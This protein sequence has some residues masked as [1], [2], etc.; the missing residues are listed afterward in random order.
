M[1][2][3]K[4]MENVIQNLNN[5]VE[6]LKNINETQSKLDNTI[7]ELIKIQETIQN[8][9]DII[10]DY[11]KNINELENRHND[12]KS[13]FDT[14]LQDYKKLHSAFELLDIELKKLNTRQENV[15]KSLID[16]NELIKAIK[17]TVSQITIA[18]ENILKS[19]Q[20][21]FDSL[22]KLTSDN[23]AK[24]LEKQKE[25]TQN[26]ENSKV[27]IKR[28]IANLCDNIDNGIVKQEEH[29]S[30]IVSDM[31]DV[32]KESGRLQKE[33]IEYMNFFEKKN[34]IRFSVLTGIGIVGLIILII[35]LFV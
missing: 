27:E 26:L 21:S 22:K 9:K 16:I 3:Y 19:Q 33:L 31:K 13:Q 17:Q 23:F 28:D 12:I 15:E 29:Y 5:Y 4:E 7:A 25:N 8:F 32:K 6:K 30:K 20:D 1:I 18:E 34:K 10:N 2:D 11:S 24:M 35:S 14:V